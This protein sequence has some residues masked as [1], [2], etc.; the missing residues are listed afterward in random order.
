MRKTQRAIA[1]LLS[2]VALNGFM[3]LSGPATAALKATSCQQDCNQDLVWCHEDCD[4]SY[5]QYSEEWQ[6]CYWSCNA[7]WNSCTSGAAWCST[8]CIGNGCGAHEY[9]CYP[10]DPETVNCWLSQLCS[11]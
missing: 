7:Y 5:T 4:S 11:C 3:L 10:P 6:S 8:W 2:S 9:T 1:V